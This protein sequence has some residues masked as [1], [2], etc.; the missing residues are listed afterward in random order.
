VGFRSD[1]AVMTDS[2][3]RALIQINKRNDSEIFSDRAAGPIQPFAQS[4]GLR[5]PLKPSARIATFF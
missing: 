3:A 4:W 1:N 5:G 2:T